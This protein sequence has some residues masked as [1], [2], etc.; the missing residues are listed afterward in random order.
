MLFSSCCCFLNVFCLLLICNRF[1]S[2]SWQISLGVSDTSKYPSTCMHC[3]TTTAVSAFLGSTRLLCGRLTRTDWLIFNVLR[4]SL[5]GYCQ[6]NS[7]KSRH[8]QVLYR[9]TCTKF[10]KS[11]PIAPYFFLKLPPVFSIPPN[12]PDYT[13]QK[14]VKVTPSHPSCSRHAGVY[15]GDFYHGLFLGFPGVTFNG[16]TLTINKFQA[17]TFCFRYFSPILRCTLHC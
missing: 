4:N 14:F 17:W 13:P 10:V 5:C 7:L 1:R 11:H 8:P 16:G 3:T 2:T 6:T 15:K 12:S 9:N